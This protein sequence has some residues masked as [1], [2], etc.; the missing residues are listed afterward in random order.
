MTDQNSNKSPL[1]GTIQVLQLVVL[2]VGV[3]GIFLAIGRRDQAIDQ[4]QQAISDL[5]QISSDLARAVGSLSIS[6]ASQMAQLQSIERRLNLIET[7]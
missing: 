1:G 3:A 6:D 5:R 4:S 2:I 7:R